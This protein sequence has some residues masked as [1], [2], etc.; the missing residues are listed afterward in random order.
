MY[1]GMQYDGDLKSRSRSQA[2]QSCK[3]GHFHKLSPLLCR[4]QREL[5]TDRGFLN[6]NTIFTLESE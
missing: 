5:T 2:L 3:S 1:D 6:Y 4:L